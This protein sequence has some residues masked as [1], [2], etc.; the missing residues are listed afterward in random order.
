MW[1]RR[2][3]LLRHSS[4]LTSG[5][6]DAVAGT[7][8]VPEEPDYLA[9]TFHQIRSLLFTIRGF[10][11]LLASGKDD[12]PI[13]TREY[14]EILQGDVERMTRLVEKVLCDSASE[15]EKL[16][17]EIKPVPLERV[18]SSVTA[19][20]SVP[21]RDKGIRVETYIDSGLPP[22]MGDELCLEQ[23][24]AN[25]VC[26]AIRHSPQSS[27]VIIRAELA[28]GGVLIS[29]QDFGVGIHRDEL[30]LVFNKY[31]RCRDNASH[32]HGLG[33]YVARQFVQAHGGQIWV[34][35]EPNLG[36]TFSL[37]LPLPI[38]AEEADCL[39]TF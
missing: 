15:A 1:N 38:Q 16:D 29:V 36:S 23:V 32:G 22:V 6:G 26:N 39:E 4:Y 27:R 14:L 12:N 31:Y 11:K 19:N 30:D 24:L 35:S 3:T 5:I 21:A 37:L 10:T 7:A 2:T 33:L 9:G 25:L 28:Y 34:E 18:I 13:K 8:V 20:F 17:L